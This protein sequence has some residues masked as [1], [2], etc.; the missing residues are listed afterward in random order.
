MNNHPRTPS[1]RHH[2]PSGQAVVTICGRDHYLGE[3]GTSQS[4]KCYDRLIAEWLAAGRSVDPTSAFNGS[5]TVTEL[6]AAHWRFAQG[7][8]QKNGSKNVELVKLRIIARP[9]RRIYGR[10][11]AAE[12]GP[13]RLKAIREEFLQA[14]LS[15]RY[16]NDQICRLRRMFRWATENELVPGHVYQSLQAVSGLRRGRSNAREYP[17]VK[18]IIDEMVDAIRP[19]VSSPV[20]AIVELQRL[21]GMRSGEAVSMRGGDLDMSGSIWHYTPA[22]H[23]TE[24]H[25]HNRAVEL[26]PRAQEVIR[27]FL[28]HDLQAYLFS[29]IDAVAEQKIEKR[30]KRKSNVQPSQLDR[31]KS[32]PSR[33]L[34][35][36]YT[37]SSYRRA[38]TRACEKAWPVPEAIIENQH[39]RATW[40]REHHWHPH[41]LRHNYATR[42]RK[43]FGV[44]A[45]RILLGHRSTAVTE[46]YA[47]IDRGR[48]R[49][50]VSRVG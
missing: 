14:G 38:V 19:F 43:E 4:R 40:Q 45:A 35:V 25:G 26:G 20:W 6:I 33:K 46:L 23:K 31:S 3:F 5:I 32:N 39:A 49:E 10:T 12:F 1:Y 22:T 29:P 41:Q 50:I 15:R 48:V 37:A 11:P 30:R 8:Y 28:R 7:Y 34:Y 13:L 36:R 2:K 24:H 42:I 44:E 27:P 18:P 47:E 21:T 16:I 17:P 9:L